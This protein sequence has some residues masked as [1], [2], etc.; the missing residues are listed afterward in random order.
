MLSGTGRATPSSRFAAA[1][2]MMVSTSSS[3]GLPVRF[4]L[5][6]MGRLWVISG[7]PCVR[8]SDACTTPNPGHHAGRFPDRLSKWP[9]LRGAALALGFSPILLRISVQGCRRLEKVIGG[10]DQFLEVQ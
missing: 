1:M 5:L 7:S 9:K 8:P 2:R 6:D 3:F 10:V 4:D